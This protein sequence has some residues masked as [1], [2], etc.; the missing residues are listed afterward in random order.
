MER[1]SAKSQKKNNIQSTDSIWYHVWISRV[2]CKFII[3]PIIRHSITFARIVWITPECRR[4]RRNRNN[5]TCAHALKQHIIAMDILPLKQA[6]PMM[7]PIIGINPLCRRRWRSKNVRGRC[8]SGADNATVT[9]S[10]GNSRRR[11]RWR[12]LCQRCRWQGW[13]DGR[14]MRRRWQQWKQQTMSSPTTNA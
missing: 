13:G 5:P 7:Y 3:L 11:R 14:L 8:S 2:V 6:Q 1:N 10:R 12:R 9:S 4:L